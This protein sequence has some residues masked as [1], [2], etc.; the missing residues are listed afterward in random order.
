[1]AT[2][3]KIT[4]TRTKAKKPV[5]KKTAVRKPGVKKKSSTTTVDSISTTLP[6]SVLKNDYVRRTVDILNDTEKSATR[7]SKRTT[8][9]LGGVVSDFREDVSSSVNGRLEQLIK[10]SKI[11]RVKQKWNE[12][13]EASLKTVDTF[14]DSLGLARKT[15]L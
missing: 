2:K 13:Y 7:L 9:Q 6:A 5:V 12:A 3:K 10:K 8:K 14:L 1:M 4:K 15:A 11:N